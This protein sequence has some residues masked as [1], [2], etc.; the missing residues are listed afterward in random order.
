MR[1]AQL[2]DCAA[3]STFRAPS[4]VEAGVP[5]EHYHHLEEYRDLS[6]LLRSPAARDRVRRALRRRPPQHRRRAV[7]APARALRRRRDPRPHALLRGVRRPRPHARGAPDHRQLPD[8]LCHD[9]GGAAM[10]DTLTRRLARLRSLPPRGAPRPARGRQRRARRRRRPP[11]RPARDP[12]ARRRVHVRARHRHDRHRRGRRDREDRDRARRRRRGKASCAISTR[13]P[14][15]ST[16]AASRPCAATRCASCGGS[17]RCARCTTAA[18]CTTPRSSTSTVSTRPRRSRW[19]TSPRD[20]DELR[21]FFDTCGY[22][23][24]R[25]VFTPDEIRGF[26][27]DTDVLRDEAREGD[28]MSWWGRDASGDDGA[29][30]GAPRR[31]PSA[32]RARC[33]TIRACSRSPASSPQPVTAR[34]KGDTDGVTVLW[35]RPT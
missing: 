16:A 25:D 3:C 30:P 20:A 6:G 14:D 1:I 12:H 9:A 5:E 29:V 27:E 32:P 31:V 8:R 11:D 21:D 19:P 13:R 22:V 33:T 17:R 34:R 35:K 7:H 15:C 26:L 18:R 2:N 10:V 28:K 24:V 23:L 4:V